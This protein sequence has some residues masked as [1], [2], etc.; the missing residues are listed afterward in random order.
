MAEDDVRWLATLG[1]R[2]ELGM[3]YDC[4][5]E[6][7]VSKSKLWHDDEMRKAC[8][9]HHINQCN[10][11]IISSNEVDDKAAALRMDNAL[12]AS[13]LCGL[14][15][16][17]GSAKYLEDKIQSCRQARVTVHHRSTTA[18]T[19]L[20][21]QRCRSNVKDLNQFE[22]KGATHVVIG[23]VYGV[24][25]FF[26][27]DRKC[28]SKEN[29][30]EVRNHL[31]HVIENEGAF[32]KRVTRLST[33]SKY[34]NVENIFCRFLVDF[35]LEVEPKT[36]KDAVSMAKKLPLMIEKNGVNSIPILVRLLSL[37]KLNPQLVKSVG[38]N[39]CSEHVLNE[40]QRILER[41]NA[42]QVRCNDLKNND[43]CKDFPQF[44]ARFEE[45]S[46]I[47]DNFIKSIK[48]KGARALLEIRSG[49]KEQTIRDVIRD[50]NQSPFRE[51]QLSVWIK[52]K[53]HEMNT[54]A[55]C[56]KLLAGVPVIQSQDDLNQLRSR[57]SRVVCFSFPLTAPDDCL[58]VLSQ[59]TDSL[60]Q[61]PHVTEHSLRSQSPWLIEHNAT[62]KSLAAHFMEL[63]KKNW[64]TQ[65]S[66]RFVVSGF[67]S[68][69]HVAILVFEQGRQV[70]TIFEPPK[71]LGS[72]V[73]HTVVHSDER[74]SFSQ[75]LVQSHEDYILDICRISQS[76]P[77]ES[78]PQ[79]L[80]IPLIERSS[81][82]TATYRSYSFGRLPS[83]DIHHKVIMLFGATG[84]GKSTLINAMI[85][86]ILGV[87][88]ED[89]YRFK[90]VD[91]RGEGRQSQAHSQTKH[92]TLYT[93]YGNR[94]HK[95]PYT[96]TLV[97]TPG[98]ANTGGIGRDKA[99]S[100]QIQDF[101][102]HSEDHHMDHI[103]AV[104]LVVQASRPR[105]TPTEVYVFDSIMSSFAFDIKRN[106]ILL[107]TFCDAKKPSVIQAI[108][109]A[110]IAH[111]ETICRFNN[112]VLYSSK[113]TYGAVDSDIEDDEDSIDKVLW[114]MEMKSMAQLFEA[115][116]H[117]E[118]ITFALLKEGLIE[119][120][121][122]TKQETQVGGGSGRK[123]VGLNH[124]KSGLLAEKKVES[125]EEKKA[126]EV[127]RDV[128][129]NRSSSA[130]GGRIRRFFKRFRFGRA[131]S[132]RDKYDHL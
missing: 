120:I 35:S 116:I 111:N 5:R 33:P 119:S 19:E 63:Y 81:S 36:Y 4:R 31:L 9:V 124:T 82:A 21:L 121:C 132:N 107:I 1:R 17:R 14:V 26:I 60:K 8:V 112:S 113:S 73:G 71:R 57:Y 100:N 66:S 94:H 7:V 101:F 23:V 80:T 92:I 74:S 37:N 128:K 115:V 50:S 95:I 93:I 102:S 52:H 122:V 64:N 99:I 46:A 11:S 75:F 109:E 126:V 20:P 85:N 105:L 70:H 87:K 6:K 90:I 86:Y 104:G 34:G 22:Q 78:D 53:E 16:V 32:G 106:I 123:E 125:T 42:M 76:D 39:S 56:L 58:I 98:F 55:E 38:Q 27:F 2:I 69:V 59:S 28:S 127:A 51:Q 61:T 88:W 41:T 89:D 129:S 77:V 91:E 131:R 83:S 96:V 40:F 68:G 110:G 47:L 103:D 13:Y 45:M 48:Q 29:A 25:S 79:I 49:G 54:V 117:L 24:Q 118:P 72:K 130:T 3:L 44:S 62:T 67:G 65:T 12:K 15:D 84:A 30:T 97:D 43:I 114:N 10:F 18:F 108:D